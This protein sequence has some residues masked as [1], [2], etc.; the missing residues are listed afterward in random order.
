MIVKFSALERMDDAWM[1]TSPKT[2]DIDISNHH[3]FLQLSQRT[4]QLTI[5][6]QARHVLYS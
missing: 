4:V 5:I 6:R 1:A 3:H 2:V